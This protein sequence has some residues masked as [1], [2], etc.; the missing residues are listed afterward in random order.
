M[1]FIEVIDEELP[2]AR[3]NPEQARK[4]LKEKVARF[5]GSGTSVYR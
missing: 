1:R 2:P 5:G 3:S 4:E